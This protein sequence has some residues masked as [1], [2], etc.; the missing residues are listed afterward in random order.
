MTARARTRAAWQRRLRGSPGQTN[1]TSP[2]AAPVAFP[3]ARSMQT[4]RPRPAAIQVRIQRL[5]LRGFEKGSE[6]RIASTFQAQLRDL[7]RQG[8]LRPD[9]QSDLSME[10]ATAGPLRLQAR[11]DPRNIGAQIARAVISC[12]EEEP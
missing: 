4:T 9:W 1:E 12:R 10:R 11:S 8:D 2:L 6:R 7:L 5:E 3:G